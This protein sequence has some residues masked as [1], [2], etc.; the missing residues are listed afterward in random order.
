MQEVED[1]AVAVSVG[2]IGLV[3]VLAN[4]RCMPVVSWAASM[5]LSLHFG[6]GR[7]LGLDCM[8]RRRR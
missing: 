2:G 6:F 7:I 5:M 4:H 8:I 1:T 3:S